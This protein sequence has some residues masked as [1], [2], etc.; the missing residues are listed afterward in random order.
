MTAWEAGSSGELRQITLIDGTDGLTHSG[1][2]DL[3]GIQG[4]LS[5]RFG[6]ECWWLC[7]QD[8]SDAL[9]GA[10]SRP[11][12]TQIVCGA[13]HIQSLG[14]DRC[15]AGETLSPLRG[16]TLGGVC[17][18]ESYGGCAEETDLESLHRLRAERHDLGRIV[19]P[20][21]L[22]GLVCS[23]LR[24]VARTRCVRDGS[25][26]TICVLMRDVSDHAAAFA[27]RRPEIER[28]LERKGPLA[29]LGLK[30]QICKPCFYT[31]HVTA[32]VQVGETPSSDVGPILTD[33]LRRFLDPVT[34][35]FSRKGW[36]IGE[37]PSAAQLR[38]VIR[39]AAPGTVLKELLLTAVGPDSREL[40]VSQVSDPFALPLS[41]EHT[42]RTV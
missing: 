6:A 32:W 15:A 26:L 1:V 20:L 13:A 12:L 18:T 9:G 4:R 41:G 38:T 5:S 33:T 40:D 21:D 24:D 3:S 14:E 8:E 39:R 19:A 35:H 11:E 25:T 23:N 2:L 37:L 42:I 27:L 16:G 28:L 34:G 31:L 22:D 7:L 29:A 17:L 30:H 10:R 36:R